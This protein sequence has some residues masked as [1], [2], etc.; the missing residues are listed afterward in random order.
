MTIIEKSQTRATTDLRQSDVVFASCCLCSFK[1]FLPI[2]ALISRVEFRA[3]RLFYTSPHMQKEHEF[4]TFR[5]STA[6]GE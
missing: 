1:T 5:K 3:T 4:Q 2:A 6:C